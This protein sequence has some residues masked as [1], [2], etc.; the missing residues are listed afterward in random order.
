MMH[1]VQKSVGGRA[2]VGRTAAIGFLA[3]VLAACD[4]PPP[5]AQGPLLEGRL[6]PPS[7]LNFIS[8][9]SDAT[10]PLQG[11]MLVLNVWAT[12]CAPC[13][14]E[15][16][17]LERLSKALDPKRF[18]VVGL[19]IDADTLLASEFLLQYGITFSNFFDQNGMILRPLELKAYPETFVIA[20]D[21][22]LV[23]RMTGLHE[24]DSPEMIR[25]LQ[26]LNPAKSGDNGGAQHVSR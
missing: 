8:G 16:P 21:R 10:G 1:L 19:S 20:P 22:T 23:R 18:A 3:L 26:S 13:R 6:F 9:G 25:M 12:W 15:M 24:W 17:G 4:G 2:C 7:V 5:S 11:R 14:R